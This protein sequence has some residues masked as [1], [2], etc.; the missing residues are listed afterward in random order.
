MENKIILEEGL[1]GALAR[2]ESLKQAMISFYNAGYKKEEIEKAARAL[3]I[4]QQKQPR[5]PQTQ[6]IQPKPIQKPLK[7]I[8]KLS[9]PKSGSIQ[10]VSGY[11][12]QPKPKKKSP[13]IILII[14]LVM[15]LGALT[16]LFLFKEQILEFFDNS[17][18]LSGLLN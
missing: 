8:K 4:Q 2:G 11:G 10:R 5:P 14:F 12:Q 13:L 7:P 18:F 15:L 17:E 3:Q 9:Q 6:Q 1:K 16:S